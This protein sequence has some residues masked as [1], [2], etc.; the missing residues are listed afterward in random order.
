MSLLTKAISLAK[1]VHEG[2]YRRDGK[3]EYFVHLVR[4]AKLVKEL[5]GSEEQIALAYLHDSVENYGG[6]RTLIIKEIK[7]IFGAQ[8]LTEV[9][10]L[11]KDEDAAYF[12]YIKK[13]KQNKK[14]ILVK[15]CDMIDNLSDQPNEKQKKKYATA[16]LKL[17][18]D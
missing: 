5:G 7:N 14:L 1:K 17:I 9:L 13:I 18:L 3:T 11:T 10:C 6:D 2:Q 4:A 15:I 8:F 16:L 12:E